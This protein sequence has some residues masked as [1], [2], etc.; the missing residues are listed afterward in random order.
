MMAE[1]KVPYQF[2]GRQLEGMIVYDDGL[3]TKRPIVFMQPDWKG[4]S[5]RP[6]DRRAQSPAK[7]TSC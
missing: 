2:N 4:V 1:K 5:A 6:S 7:T 3:S